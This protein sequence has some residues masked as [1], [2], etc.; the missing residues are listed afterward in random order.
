M[1][2]FPCLIQVLI[3]SQPFLQSRPSMG[4]NLVEGGGPKNSGFPWAV[5]AG[6]IA[7]PLANHGSPR[8]T[9][10]TSFSP[11][12]ESAI[13]KAFVSR[14]RRSELSSRPGPGLAGPPCGPIAVLESRAMPLVHS[15]PIRCRCGAPRRRPTG[16]STASLAR[17]TPRAAPAGAQLTHESSPPP[18]SCCS[19]TWYSP[20]CLTLF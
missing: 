8:R 15:G 10:T 17:R 7:F 14:E 2:P 13:R 12:L 18:R 4:K 19:P 6:Q 3:E 1:N 16:R 5:R 11:A 20:I 9:A